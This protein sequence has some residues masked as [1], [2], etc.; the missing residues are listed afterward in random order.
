MMGL[1]M[2]TKYSWKVIC[3]EC[4]CEKILPFEEVEHTEFLAKVTG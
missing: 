1:M 2:A 3:P 4:G